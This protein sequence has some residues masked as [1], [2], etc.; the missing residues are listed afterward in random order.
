MSLFS[1]LNHTL[2]FHNWRLFCVLQ[3]WSAF[4][5]TIGKR[6]TFMTISAFLYL[7]TLEIQKT[8][9]YTFCSFI[10]GTLCENLSLPGQKTQKISV[11]L[12]FWRGRSWLDCLKF[13]LCRNWYLYL[14][15]LKF[16]SSPFSHLWELW[17]LRF[18]ILSH[19]KFWLRKNLYCRC[20]APKLI[21]ESWYHHLKLNIGHFLHKTQ[22][23]PW[24]SY[25][26]ESWYHHLELNIGHF[27]DSIQEIP[28]VTRYETVLKA[29]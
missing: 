4:S 7:N 29:K 20:S 17:S 13:K 18:W 14:M 12:F 27:L 19:V 26:I 6:L 3:N 16:F 10:N 1:L 11:G 23:I 8:V 2:N 22:Q 24:Y 25:N 5:F 15:P 9:S 21:I 28:T